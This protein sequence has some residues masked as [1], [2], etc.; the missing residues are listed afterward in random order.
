M[1]AVYK[2]GRA[3]ISANLT[4]LIDVVFLLIV[5]FVL[6]SQIV[7]VEHVDLDLPE[8][9]NALTMKPTEEHRVVMNVMPD[10]SDR[11]A[12]TGY[13]LGGREFDATT[14]GVTAMVD[15]LAALFQDDP[16]LNVNLRADR[17][18]HYEWVEPAM[19]AISQAA[20]KAG[21]SDLLPRV[22]LMVIQ[23]D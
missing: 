6:V 19:H 14:E 4:P 7:E 11:G 15:H 9:K 8:P 13:K 22:N 2:K 20:T 3:D 17:S 12:I 23:E 5:F 1:S 16:D 10:R 18:T 21:I